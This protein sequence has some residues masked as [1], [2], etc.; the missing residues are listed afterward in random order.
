MYLTSDFTL[1]SVA[2]FY[3]M[4][5]KNDISIIVLISQRKKTIYK[6]QLTM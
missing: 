4:N 5:D 6:L 1:I 3:F 2:I